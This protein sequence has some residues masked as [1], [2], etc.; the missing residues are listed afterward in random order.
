MNP[1]FSV[2][3]Y[4]GMTRMSVRASDGTA[5]IGHLDWNVSAVA[6]SLYVAPAHRRQGLGAELWRR[7][8]DTLDGAILT[9]SYART[10]L[11]ELFFLS[12]RVERPA[13]S[14]LSLP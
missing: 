1:T 11:G 2:G 5:E 12:Q 10:V 4:C 14:Y 7:A 3:R 8:A 9:P 13:W 6:I